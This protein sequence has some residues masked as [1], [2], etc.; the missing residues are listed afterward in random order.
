[1]AEISSEN[2]FMINRIKVSLAKQLVPLK[3]AIAGPDY[4]TL[5]YV[6][7]ELV[8]SNHNV[9]NILEFFYVFKKIKTNDI[10]TKANISDLITQA[11]Y[12]H[13]D[14]DEETQMDLSY[15][16]DIFKFCVAPV[17]LYQEEHL[18]E[19]CRLYKNYFEKQPSSLKKI[20]DR[21]SLDTCEMDLKCIELYQWLKNQMEEGFPSSLEEISKVKGVLITQINNFLI[22]KI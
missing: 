1:M 16:E 7:E 14:I 20:I 5:A 13:E 21:F 12:L 6:N 11:E 10:F 2:I 19:F 4:D 18:E 8:K 15:F 22:K 9:M 3:T 17:M